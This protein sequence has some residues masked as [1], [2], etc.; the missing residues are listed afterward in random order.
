[1]ILIIKT[2]LK[3]KKKKHRQY[4]IVFKDYITSFDVFHLEFSRATNIKYQYRNEILRVFYSFFCFQQLFVLFITLQ[5]NDI[6]CKRL[7]FS[8]FILNSLI[9]VEYSVLWVILV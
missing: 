1:M 3:K 9:L 4:K 8:N 6:L 2:L 7:N 5:F